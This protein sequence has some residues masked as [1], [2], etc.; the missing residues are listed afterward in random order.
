M[1]VVSGRNAGNC[2]FSDHL[3]VCSG[4]RRAAEKVLNCQAGKVPGVVGVYL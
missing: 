2:F 1:R 4:R 3:A